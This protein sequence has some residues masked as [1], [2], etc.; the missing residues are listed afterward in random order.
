MT[1]PTKIDDGGAAFPCESAQVALRNELAKQ[2]G[3]E[4]NEMLVL[5]NKNNG[6][7]LRDWFAGQAL[8]GILSRLADST[9]VVNGVPLTY[10]AFAYVMADAMIAEKRK[11]EAGREGE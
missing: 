2:F 5:A 6:M 9:I 8:A 3:Y 1:D 11:R 10:D 4:I 7:T